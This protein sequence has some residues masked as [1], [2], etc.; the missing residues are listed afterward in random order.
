MFLG[1]AYLQQRKFDNALEEFQRAVD[2]SNGAA[3]AIGLLGHCHAVAGEK[4]EA[5]RL[6]DKLQDL[7]HARYV[8]PDFMAW[9]HM[10]LG[11]LDEAFRFL[12][13]AYERRSN[14]LA[15]LHPDPRFD[16]LRG[17]ARFEKLQRD[18]ALI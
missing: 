5:L 6:L 15:W 1:Q 8:S 3:F 9:I 11:D 18:V 16:P 12:R 10:G 13:A 14:W 17:D 4:N 7:S 2:L